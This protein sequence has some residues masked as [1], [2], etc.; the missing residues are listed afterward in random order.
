MEKIS[1]TDRGNNEL[2]GLQTQVTFYLKYK[3]AN[4]IGHIKR[5]NCLLKYVAEGKIQMMSRRGRRHEHL[6]TLGKHTKM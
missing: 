3:T 4:W 5:R 6:T 1:W 2:L